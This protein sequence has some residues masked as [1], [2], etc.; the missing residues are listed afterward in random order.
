[1]EYVLAEPSSYVLAISH[2]GVKHYQLTSKRTIEADAN[3]YRKEIRSQKEDKA[4]AQKLFN[5]LLRQIPEVA[6]KTDLIVIPDGALHLL[7]FLL[8][9]TAKAISLAAILWT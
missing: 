4:L 1:M 3:Q 7:P 6:D 2:D 9:R 5:E 8:F